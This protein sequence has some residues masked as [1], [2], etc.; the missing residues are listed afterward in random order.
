MPKER[1]SALTRI[2]ELLGLSEINS[3]LAQHANCETIGS[4]SSPIPLNPTTASQ[5]EKTDPPP[6]KELPENSYTDA[7]QSQSLSSLPATTYGDTRTIAA[8]VGRSAQE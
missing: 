6:S 3:T 8:G 5:V 1:D 2:L 4:A 7:M